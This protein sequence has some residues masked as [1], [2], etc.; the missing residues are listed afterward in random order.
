MTDTTDAGAGEP[1]WLAL[2]QPTTA[3]LTGGEWRPAAVLVVAE[4]PEFASEA[5]RLE[6]EL[7]ALGIPSGEGATVRL[8]RGG[9]DGEAFS[10]AVFDD[11]EVVAGAPVGVFRASRQLLHNLRAQGHVPYGRV[12]SEP[13]VGEWGFHLDAARKHFPA[14]W[15]FG[16]LRSLADVGINSFHWHFSENEGFRLESASFPEIVS[17]DHVTRD[18][19]RRIVEVA[20]DLHLDVVPSLDMPG[21]L[22][23]FLTAHPEFRLPSGALDTDHA[24]DRNAGSRLTHTEFCE[25]D[26]RIGVMRNAAASA[27]SVYHVARCPRVTRSF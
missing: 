25:F 14:E 23:H 15:I 16:L 11:I 2:P 10:L 21:H 19:A 7:G 20:A 26:A 22:R 1:R 13:S 17:A 24:L 27:R 3:T 5:V 6:R 12:A 8:R 18:Q 4:A 9:P